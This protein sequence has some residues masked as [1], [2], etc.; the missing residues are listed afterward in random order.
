MYNLPDLPAGTLTFLFTDID[1]STLLWEQDPDLMQPA[2]VRHDE[3]VEACVDE[4]RGTLVR[5][6]GEGDSRFAVFKL[7]SDAAVAAIAI[8]CALLIEHWSLISQ[9]RVRNGLHT[10][11]A[12][13][14]DG[15]Y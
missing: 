11:E 14:R 10:G 2:M 13:L 7:A 6:R 15:D 3:L 9:L 4:Y 12:N 5:P 8:P 1:N